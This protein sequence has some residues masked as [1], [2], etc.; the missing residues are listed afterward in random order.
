LDFAAGAAETQ[1]FTARLASQVEQVVA[2]TGL[3]VVLVGH[4]AGPVWTKAML[5]QQTED[6]KNKHVAGISG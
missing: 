5:D 3:P 6:W 1:P 4:S 2:D